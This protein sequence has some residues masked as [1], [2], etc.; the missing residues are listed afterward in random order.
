MANTEV[1]EIKEPKKFILCYKRIDNFNTKVYRVLLTPAVCDECGL[2]LMKNNNIKGEYEFLHEEAKVRIKMA[3][4][5]HKRAVHDVANKKIIT[6][7]QM[8]VAYLSEYVT[9]KEAE[10]KLPDMYSRFGVDGKPQPGYD[11]F[12][13]LISKEE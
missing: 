5:E 12:G 2:D 6:E 13:R 9:K 8:P 1:K 10:E 3:V 7:D 4:A 11:K